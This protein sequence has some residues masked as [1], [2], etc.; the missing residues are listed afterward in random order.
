MQPNSRQDAELAKHFL[1]IG[2]VVH[3]YMEQFLQ[4]IPRKT[5][6]RIT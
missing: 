2:M 6:E 1:S 5:L 4:D 3:I